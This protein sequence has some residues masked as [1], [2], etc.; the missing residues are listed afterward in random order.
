MFGDLLSE[1]VVAHWRVR[2]L[3]LVAAHREQDDW[4]AGQDLT[5]FAAGDGA[6][7]DQRIGF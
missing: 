5:G 7:V 6:H 1:K 2:A 3:V 4:V